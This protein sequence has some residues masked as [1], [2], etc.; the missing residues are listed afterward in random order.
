MHTHTCTHTHAHIHIHTHTHAHTHTRTHM[1]CA[2]WWCCL[3]SSL[4][5]I[6]KRNQ[7]W[8]ISESR[9]QLAWMLKSAPPCCGADLFLVFDAADIDCRQVS[10]HVSGMRSHSARQITPISHCWCRCNTTDVDCRQE[11][12]EVIEPGRSHLF[13]TA[14]VDET[15]LIFTAGK[16]HEMLFSQAGDAHFMLLMLMKHHWCWLQVSGPTSVRCVRSHSARQVTW[17]LISGS[18][19]DSDR[20]PVTDAQPRELLPSTVNN[21]MT[22]GMHRN[23]PSDV[24]QRGLQ[25]CDA[26]G[27]LWMWE[28]LLLE[29][30]GH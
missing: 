19:Q 1:S 21:L 5:Y 6:M 27:S 10:V 29:M 4:T 13:H 24:S 7:I 14:D 26:C 12:W 22:G 9:S 20:S 16:W 17:Q 15:P 3:L 18:T 25:V 23:P 2:L 30:H 28:K 8:S 11:A